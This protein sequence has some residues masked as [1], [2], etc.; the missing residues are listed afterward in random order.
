[1]ENLPTEIQQQIITHTTST[2]LGRLA[3]VSRS[4][5]L[6]C[7]DSQIWEVM[8]NDYFGGDTSTHTTDFRE[9]LI[10]N[11][12]EMNQK[13]HVKKKLWWTLQN[14][15]FNALRHILQEHP[16]EVNFNEQGIGWLYACC[17]KFNHYEC[18]QVLLMLGAKVDLPDEDLMTP[19]HHAC[20]NGY[21]EIASLLMSYGAN[22]NWQIKKGLTPLHTA[23][24][25]NHPECV[26]VLLQSPEIN[27]DLVE[28]T[29]AH[30]A[31]HVACAL[32][33]LE[34]VKLLLLHNAN[35]DLL[36]IEGKTAAFLCS[37]NGHTE[38]VKLFLSYNIYVP[39][40]YDEEM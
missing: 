25:L 18:A 13:E 7:E 6:L 20:M 30:T 22:P 1:M 9:L 39:P 36:N 23:T 24:F 14:N 17:A 34:I 21:P 8:N 37:S 12:R 11:I 19:L 29:L 16:E 38:I 15:H 10:K 5:R 32:G 2:D 28:E 35:T 31:L 33:Y 40:P 4:F 27:I 3:C 26:A